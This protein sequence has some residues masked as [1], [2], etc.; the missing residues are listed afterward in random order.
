MNVVAVIARPRI[1]RTVGVDRRRYQVILEIR[2]FNRGSLFKKAMQ[3]IGNTE[4]GPPP[5]AT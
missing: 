5:V 2:S 1:V 4:S 3:F